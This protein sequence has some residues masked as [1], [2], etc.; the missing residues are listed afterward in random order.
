MGS[1]QIKYV[2]I[3]GHMVEEAIHDLNF[4]DS[5]NSWKKNTAIIR[6]LALFF[7]MWAILRHFHLNLGMG[8]KG[9][10]G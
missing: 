3:W 7:K 1:W 6:V 8:K 2:V 5:K 10:C 4:H 9:E